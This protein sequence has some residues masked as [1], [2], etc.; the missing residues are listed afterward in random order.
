[1]AIFPTGIVLLF[2]FRFFKEYD[3]VILEFKRE[4]VKKPIDKKT[5][6]NSPVCVNNVTLNLKKKYDC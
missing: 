3:F 2:C 5:L 6:E 1:M 4:V